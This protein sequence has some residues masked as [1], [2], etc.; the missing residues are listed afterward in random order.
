MTSVTLIELLQ[1]THHTGPHVW[2]DIQMG[3]NHLTVR[4]DETEEGFK[5]YLRGNDNIG[6]DARVAI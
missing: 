3:D 1:E 4:V 6:H 5:V 2:V